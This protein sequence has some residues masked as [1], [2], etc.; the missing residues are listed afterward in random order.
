[1][2]PRLKQ[3]NPR[4]FVPKRERPMALCLALSSRP[5]GLRHTRRRTLLKPLYAVAVSPLGLSLVV[6]LGAFTANSV[7][8]PS[9]QMGTI[10]VSAVEGWCQ[11]PVIPSPASGQSLDV[12]PCGQS[13][14]AVSVTRLAM[15]SRSMADTLTSGSSQAEKDRVEAAVLKDV[16]TRFGNCLESSYTIQFSGPP[17]LPGYEARGTYLCGGKVVEHSTSRGYQATEDGSLFAI[18]ANQDSSAPNSDVDGLINSLARAI[19][20][21]A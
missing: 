19:S 6:F 13:F 7:E 2:G 3:L 16:S 8:K 1:M 17:E 14:P 4:L 11:S 20:V 12:A 5:L 10:S 18:D 21:S 15:A 9:W